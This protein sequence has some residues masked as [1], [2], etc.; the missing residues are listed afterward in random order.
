MK[1][2]AAS[3]NGLAAAFIALWYQSRMFPVRAGIGT[4]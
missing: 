2:N 4:L 3:P 1:K